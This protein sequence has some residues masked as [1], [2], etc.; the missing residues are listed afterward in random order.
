MKNPILSSVVKKTEIDTVLRHFHRSGHR[1]YAV[2]GFP[3]SRDIGE[4]PYKRVI[5]RKSI[6]VR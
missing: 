2:R 3:R 1:S 4:E 6:I 5:F